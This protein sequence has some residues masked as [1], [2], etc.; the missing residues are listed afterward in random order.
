MAPAHAMINGLAV[1]FARITMLAK[2]PT[3]TTGIAPAGPDNIGLDAGQAVMVSLQIA[4]SIM[5]AFVIQVAMIL[6]LLGLAVGLFIRIVILWITTAFMPFSFLGYVINGKLGTTIF[7]FETD[8]WKEFLIAAFLPVTVAIPIVIGFIM[9]SAVATVPAP[10]GL[11]G[12]LTIGVPLLAGVK[13]WWQL[14]WMMAAIGIIWTGA[15]TALS[16]SK[17]T[18]KF[19]D[20]IKGFGESV[21]GTVA[22]IPL[23]TPIPLPNMNANLGTLVNA[24]KIAGGVITSMTS[25]TNNLTL[26]EAFKQ[27]M[28]LVPGAANIDQTA[29][30]LRN[31]DANTDKIVIAVRELQ[32]AGLNAAQRDTHFKSIRDALGP[33]HSHLS[34]GQTI[35]LIQ[36]IALS[37]NAPN[38]FKDANTAEHIRTLRE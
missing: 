30:T 10:P 20:K 29:A 22:K 12:S 4:M 17:I 31:Q 9:L 1:S 34:N 32:N 28:G 6:P 8:I 13:T 19:T 27:R 24:H 2:I 26:E 7:E 25:G 14:L 16:K 11:D 23:L 36:N 38:Q 21:F 3:S 15:F 35:S 33:E 18:G 5:L 37:T